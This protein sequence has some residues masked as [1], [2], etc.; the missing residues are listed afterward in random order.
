MGYSVLGKL[1]LH[2]CQVV[3]WVLL[4]VAL[5]DRYAL[6]HLHQV[7]IFGL[8]GWDGGYQGSSVSNGERGVDGL[9]HFDSVKG[10]LQSCSGS[11]R[12]GSRLLTHFKSVKKRS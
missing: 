9:E 7:S 10:R 5:K 3:Y 12:Y 6:F 8:F 11:W 2:L 1:L 4:V